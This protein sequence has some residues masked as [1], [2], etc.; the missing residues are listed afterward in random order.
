MTDFTNA[1]IR[2]QLAAAIRPTF[3]NV[4]H[5]DWDRLKASVT[6][7]FVEEMTRVNGLLY[8]AVVA[9]DG[10]VTMQDMEKVASALDRFSVW[11]ESRRYEAK[12]LPGWRFMLGDGDDSGAAFYKDGKLCVWLRAW[13]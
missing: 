10:P 3:V 6:V 13:K 4:L 8:H 12:A 7:E 1:K 11:Q 5:R 9:F 2:T